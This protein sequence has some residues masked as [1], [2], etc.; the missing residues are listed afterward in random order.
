MLQRLRAS[1]DNVTFSAAVS[2]N[3]TT[4]LV[5]L[6]MRAPASGYAVMNVLDMNG[7]QLSTARISLL[8]GVNYHELNLGSK[9]NGMYT[10]ELISGTAKQ[11][12]KV[13]V[14]K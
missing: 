14:S 5:K 3:P 6:T 10:I 2:P 1:I 4:G 13:I 7:K 12:L 8:K 9:A 11:M